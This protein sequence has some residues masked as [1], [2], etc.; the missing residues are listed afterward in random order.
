MQCHC[1]VCDC[2]APCSFWVHHCHATDKDSKWKRLRQSKNK[3]QPNPKRR[4]PQHFNRSVT[5]G[6]SSQYSVNV[7]G[8]SGRFPAPSPMPRTIPSYG[9]KGAQVAPPLYTS[10]NG[11]HLQPSVPSYGLVQPAWPHASQP[12]QVSGHVSAETF[13]RYPP[14]FPVGAPMGYQGHQYR[15]PSYPQLAPN[16]VVGTGVPLSRCSSLNTQAQGTQR[17]QVLSP[18]I[19]SKESLANL[20]RQLGLSDY[21][22]NQPLGQQS[23]STPQYMHMHPTDILL[24]QGARK[25]AYVKKSYVAATSQIGASSHNS[26]NHAP[27]GTVVSSGSVQ[28]QQPLCQLKPG[29]VVSSGSVQIQQPLCQLKPGTV[30]SSGSVQTQQPLCQLKSQSSVTPGGTAP[31][32]LYLPQP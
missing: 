31:N 32:T 22:T 26:S 2:P 21:N 24:A 11:N 15:P 14:Q 4:L 9:S 16:T 10:S 27:G 23:T 28:I 12:A 13:Q 8:F 17:P 1:Y 29:T 5:T 19:L 6:P 3:I 30:L 25:E 7:T 20:A 18:G